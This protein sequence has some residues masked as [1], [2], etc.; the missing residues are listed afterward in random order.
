VILGKGNKRGNVIAGTLHKLNLF[1]QID[2]RRIRKRIQHGE[3]DGIVGH[4]CNVI[5]RIV[6]DDIDFALENF[7][8]NKRISFNRVD[9]FR[10]EPRVNVL[11]C[12][13]TKSID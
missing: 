11:G 13:D 10:Q 3:V 5:V 12:I 2:R 8:R 1:E 7:T 4:A 9:E 6:A